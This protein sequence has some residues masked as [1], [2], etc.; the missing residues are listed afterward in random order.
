MRAGFVI[1]LAIE[2]FNATNFSGWLQRRYRTAR[3]VTIVSAS[4]ASIDVD[5]KLYFDHLD[6]NT[7]AGTWVPASDCVRDLTHTSLD[8]LSSRSGFVITG[9]SSVV[10]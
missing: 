10:M 8:V 2:S 6:A 5:A 7:A 4:A 3:H 9:L 1:N